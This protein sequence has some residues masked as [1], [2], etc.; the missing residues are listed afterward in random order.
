MNPYSYADTVR[1]HIPSM[2]CE[3]D[4]AMLLKAITA[5]EPDAEVVCDR[6]TREIAI[7]PISADAVQ[8]RTA[9][10]GAG[11]CITR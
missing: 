4:V 5:V 6:E 11:F 10:C 3:H 7:A 8:F 2:S 9:I 1:F